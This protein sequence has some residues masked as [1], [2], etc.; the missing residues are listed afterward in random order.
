MWGK[1]NYL[2]K[3]IL[4]Y[5]QLLGIKL[6]A[7]Y[8]ISYSKSKSEITTNA[9]LLLTCLHMH[10]KCICRRWL[11]I[12][13]WEIFDILT[14]FFKGVC[15]RFVVSGKGLKQVKI[16]ILIEWVKVKMSDKTLF[17]RFSSKFQ[18]LYLVI[19]RMKQYKK[20]NSS[21]LT[22]VV[23]SCCS[24]AIFSIYLPCINFKVGS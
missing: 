6:Y 2:L 20:H 18:H 15:C 22:E 17:G 11:M 16:I 21:L 8:Q 4:L 19:G 1:K 23:Y 10:L 5:I 13:F 12:K 14:R 3:N 7:S 9:I 24:S